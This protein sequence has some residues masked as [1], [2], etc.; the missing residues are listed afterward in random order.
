[1]DKFHAGARS[2]EPNDDLKKNKEGKSQ[3]EV[4]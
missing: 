3:T 4:D 2:S 1:V